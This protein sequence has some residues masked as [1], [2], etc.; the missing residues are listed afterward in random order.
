MDTRTHLHTRIDLLP[1]GFTILRKYIRGIY[2]F[3]RFGFVF[4]G[5]SITV[6]S[7][8]EAPILALNFLETQLSTA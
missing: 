3:F 6:I 8:T 1:N 2:N 7:L 4:W 5:K